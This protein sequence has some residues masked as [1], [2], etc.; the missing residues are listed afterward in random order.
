[1]LTDIL[2]SSLY[3]LIFLVAA[4][5]ILA[6][7]WAV[8]DALTPGHK[9][10]EKIAGSQVARQGGTGVSDA[11]HSAALVTSVWMIAQ[12]AIIFTAI[13]TNARGTDFWAAL[14]WTVAFSIVGLLLQTV[15]F[16]ALDKF[17][18]GELGDEVCTPGP[19]IPLAK[20]AAANIAAV[21]LIV[22]ASIS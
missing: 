22:I 6:A 20:V 19:V 1:M 12:A 14:G 9:L 21:G 16:I 5:L 3:A 7:G 10:G 17:T 2:W 18:P 15:A 4:L 8:L 11:S 13:Y